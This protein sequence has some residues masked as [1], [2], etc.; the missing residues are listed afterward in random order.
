MQFS[1]M[2][3]LDK[4]GF[5]H[6]IGTRV[7]EKVY[8]QIKDIEE[9]FGVPQSDIVRAALVYGLDKTRELM[10]SQRELEQEMV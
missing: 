5:K 9:E 4:R 1:T 2:A 8:Q 3:V 10:N 7:S 6:R